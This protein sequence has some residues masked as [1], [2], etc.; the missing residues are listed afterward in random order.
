MVV[1]N[2]KTRQSLPKFPKTVK[3]GGFPKTGNPP[4]Q[5]RWNSQTMMD[6][7]F[8]EEYVKYYHDAELERISRICQEELAR[9]KTELSDN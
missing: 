4:Y 5:K 2:W 3:T 6:L 8:F 9:R 1:R 7:E